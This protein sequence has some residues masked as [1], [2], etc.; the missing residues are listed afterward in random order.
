MNRRC[1]KGKPCG[2]TCIEREKH[3]LKDLGD[4]VS[5]SLGH[6]RKDL[7]DRSPVYKLEKSSSADSS[8]RETQMRASRIL[9]ALRKEGDVV[10][11]NGVVKEEYVNWR[12]FLGS[13]VRAVGGGHFGSFAIIPSDKLLPNVKKKG[14]LPDE[15]GVKVG[16][17]GVNEVQAIKLAGKNDLGPKLISSRVSSDIKQI[18][19]YGNETSKG[20][21]AMTIVPGISY[22]FTP[23]KRADG[24]LVP[25]SELY[26][27]AMASLHRLGIAHNDM[28]GRNVLVDINGPYRARFVDY[29]LAQLSSKA[30]M[31]EALGA[32]SGKNYKFVASNTQGHAYTF[33]S[34]MKYVEQLLMDKGFNYKEIRTIM[35][36]GIRKNIDFFNK[37]AWGKITE[38][39]AKSFINDLY[40]G[41][42]D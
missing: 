32:I 22:L 27:E 2:L 7:R 31:A 41:I 25:K 37:G 5:K 20:A 13:N 29:G 17:I 11:T 36:G 9:N 28:H 40:A 42:A 16:R 39:E 3:C 33:K 8:S 26:W 35:E 30:A 1:G 24:F 4:I 6:V 18:K 21:I 14:S 38:S 19:I 12:A 34:N 23:S 10:K 15:I